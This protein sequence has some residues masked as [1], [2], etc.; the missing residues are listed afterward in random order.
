MREYNF[1][2]KGKK[3]DATIVKQKRGIKP[4][5]LYLGKNDVYA[6]FLISKKSSNLLKI[7]YPR[8]KYDE[9]LLNI[10]KSIILKYLLSVFIITLLS[11]FYAY[12]A[13]YPMKKALTL[14][15]EFLKDVIHDINT[16]VTTILLNSKSLKRKNPSDEVEWIELSAKKIL[17]LYKNFEADIKGVSLNIRK[18][19]IY[20]LLRK[21]VEYF[22]RLYPRISINISGESVYWPVDD[23]AFL[24][25][26][27]NL[28]SNSC[29]YS[30]QRGGRVDIEVRGKKIVIKDNGI[31]IKNSKK[32]FERFYKESDRGIGIGLNIVQ[33]L[34]KEMGIDIKLISKEGSGTTVQ[35][36]LK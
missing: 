2:F 1:N 13:L 10:R 11:V 33:K 12:Y 17:A 26:I 15:E 30:K 18:T 34:C 32:V 9:D 5:K 23:E 4:D 3:F 20:A 28:L 25:I 19:D 29:K 6:L 36:T 7:I 14:I 24:R 16:P 31:G 8:D 21:R 35:L 27:D 22:K